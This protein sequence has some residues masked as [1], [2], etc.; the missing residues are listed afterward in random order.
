MILLDSCHKLSSLRNDIAIAA[1]ALHHAVEI[2][3]D[4]VHFGLLATV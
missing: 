1:C 4:D 2:E 3:H